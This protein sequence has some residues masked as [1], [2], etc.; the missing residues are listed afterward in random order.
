MGAPQIAIVNRSKLPDDEL[1]F[2]AK[3]CDAQVQECAAVWGVPPTVVAFYSADAALPQSQCRILAVVDDLDEPGALGFHD[4]AAGIVYARV[5]NQ[6]RDTS[7]TISHECLEEMIDPTCD[8]WRD[9]GDGRSTALEVCDAVEGDS[10]TITVEILGEVRKIFVSNYLR[11]AWFDPDGAGDLDRMGKLTAPFTMT[12]GGYMIVR[13]Q[14]GN[15]SDVFAH[16]IV[17]GSAGGRLAMAARLAN[18]DSRLLRR[19]RVK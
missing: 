10:Y 6:S 11:P 15:E 17:A 16:R 4:D 7:I 19:L 3:A 12:P 8:Q 9:M 5:L 13:D 18:P 2:A 14:L 1:A